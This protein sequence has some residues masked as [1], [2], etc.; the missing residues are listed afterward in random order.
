M[1]ALQPWINTLLL[2]CVTAV[3]GWTFVV[4]QDAIALYGVIPFL[5][6]RFALAATALAPLY[7]PRVTRR[8]LLVGGSIGVVLALAYFFQ[9]AGLLFTTPT[10]SGLITGLFVVF[11]PLAD[12]I[13]FGV[14][15]SRQ[16]LVA[17]ILSLLGMVLLAGGGP[18]GVNPG[19][20]LT[21]LCAAA[22]GVHIALLSRYAAGHDAGGLTLAQILAM[23]ILF[24]AL[25]PFFEPLEFPPTGVWIS[26]L[27]T[28]LVAS[29]AAF[30][31]QTT[32]Q[33][34][35]PA[36]RTA[37]ILTME[38]VFAAIFGYWL[39][40]DRLSVLQV[41]GAALILSALFVGEVSPVIRRRK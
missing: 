10:N 39:A 3:W 35:I 7:V 15:S 1:T 37:I 40:G 32:V 22:L 2:I 23:T 33:Q 14:K 28:G 4:V 29:A 18:E 30:Y 27:V 41:A 16:V 24:A 25:W 36:A 17:V 19:D 8:T 34:H 31:V 26:L 21:L 38:P 12:R 20:F 9:T 5:A 13:L 11:A 6:V